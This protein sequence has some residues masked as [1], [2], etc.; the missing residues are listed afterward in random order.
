MLLDF[1]RLLY[2]TVVELLRRAC[3]G[4]AQRLGPLH[5]ARA[6]F[7]ELAC[8]RRMEALVRR[9]F[10][11][12]MKIDMVRAQLRSGRNCAAIEADTAF[13]RMLGVVKTD[14]RALQCEAASWQNDRQASISSA[15]LSAAL[16]AAAAMS[17]R[18]YCLADELLW[19]LAERDRQAIEPQRRAADRADQA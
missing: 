7:A 16:V 17:E 2:L 3:V 18:I 10:A 13:R 1:S 12:G 11:M 5:S 19:E 6:W 14:M 15:R 9:L 8:A 4:L